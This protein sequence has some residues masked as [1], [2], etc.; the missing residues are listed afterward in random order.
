MSDLETLIIWLLVAA[1]FAS[2]VFISWQIADGDM[3][4]RRQMRDTE[5]SGVWDKQIEADVKAG[6]LDDIANQAIEDFKA[7]KAKEL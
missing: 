4:F 3:R 1:F 2:L 5:R 6:K 7:G